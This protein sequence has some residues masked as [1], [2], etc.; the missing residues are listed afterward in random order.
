MSRRITPAFPA[1][2]TQTSRLHPRRLAEPLNPE[3]EGV[4]PGR[5]A[6]LRVG[7]RMPPAD[8][9]YDVGVVNVTAAISVLQLALL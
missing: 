5:L 3:A 2:T 4:N 7:Y 9:P 1:A 6:V 8:Q